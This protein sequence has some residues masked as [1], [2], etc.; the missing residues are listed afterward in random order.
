[1][2]VK[3]LGID[4]DA[5]KRQAAGR[6]DREQRRDTLN[7]IGEFLLDLIP[8]RSAIVNFRNGNFKDSATDLAFDVFGFLTAGLGMVGKLAKVAGK[9]GN[10]LAKVAHSTRVIGA[11]ALSAFNPLGGLDDLIVGA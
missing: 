6:T 10:A 2:V 1:T 7:S 8:L 5:V 9:T 4:S 11:T 3:G